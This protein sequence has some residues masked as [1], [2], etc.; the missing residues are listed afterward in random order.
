MKLNISTFILVLV[1]YMSMEDFILKWLPLSNTMYSLSR[2]VSEVILYILLL[3]I[4]I[5][6]VYTG[7][8]RRTDIDI[9]LGVLIFLGI[10]STIINGAPLVGGLIKMKALFRYFA[11]FYILINIYIPENKKYFLI[12]IIILIA[13]LQSLLGIYQHFAGIN[14]IWMPRAS[15][16]EVAGYSK[17][18]RVLDGGIEKG[19]VIGLFGH[20]VSMSLYL[21]IAASILIVLI[22]K[23]YRMFSIYTQYLFL[24]IIS[25]GISYTYSRGSLIAIMGAIPFYLVVTKKFKTLV[26]LTSMII[27]GIFML[28]IFSGF[29]GGKYENVKDKY[30]NPINNFTMVFSSEYVDNAENSRLWMITKVA[31]TVLSS[32]NVFGYGADEETARKKILEASDNTLSRIIYYSGFEDVYWVALLSYYGIFGVSLFLYILY[33]IYKS[34]KYVYLNTPQ[35]IMKIISLSMLGIIIYTIP[36]T[37]LV[38]TFEFRSF[39]FY[40][41]LLAGLIFQEYLKLKSEK[42]ENFIST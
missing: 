40:F 11:L 31:S 7:K 27:L 6:K 10:M 38:R 8:I 26:I 33:E 41:F 20:S 14:E 42:N 35:E 15:M 23:K 39:S 29:S 37:F 18:F 5:D 21:F 17:D 22:I 30:V 12:K 32:F 36:L 24:F 34:S 19:A 13:F 2:F 3:L 28:G 16:L 1:I 9:P 4:I 25:M